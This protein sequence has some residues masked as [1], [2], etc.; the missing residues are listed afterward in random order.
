MIATARNSIITE[1]DFTL[2]ITVNV[3]AFDSTTIDLCLNEFWWQ[4]SELQKLL[5]K[6]HTLY[7]IKTAIP[8]FV[9]ITP[10]S[11]HDVNALDVFIIRSRWLLHYG[12]RIC[13]F[14]KALF[15]SSM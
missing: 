10:G 15:Y 13:R 3:Y 2:D 7:D 14:H 12:Q 6:L 1:P 9:H 4:L 5:F 11:V 8:S